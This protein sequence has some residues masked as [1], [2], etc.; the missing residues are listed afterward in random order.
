MLKIDNEQGELTLTRKNDDHHLVIEDAAGKV[1]YD[2]PFDPVKGVDGLPEMARK[3]LETMKLD[4]LEIR[5]PE[6]PEPTPEKTTEP[7]GSGKKDAGSPG[8]L[9]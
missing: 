8:E 7:K 3:Q 5:L 2:G 1:V 6:T 9:L 4:N